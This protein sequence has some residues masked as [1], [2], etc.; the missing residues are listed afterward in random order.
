[1]IKNAWK[2]TFLEFSYY[3][4]REKYELVLPISSKEVFR[5]IL[6]IS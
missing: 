6:D 1:M 5:K 4:N 3:K 2:R